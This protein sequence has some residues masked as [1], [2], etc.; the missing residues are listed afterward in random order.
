MI[1][2]LVPTFDCGPWLRESLDSVLGQSHGDREIVVVD[3]GSTDDTPAILASYGDHIRV[4]AGRHEGLAAARNLAIANARGTWIAFHDADDVA[5]PDRL[6]WQIAF[7]HAHPGWDAVFASGERLDGAGRVVPPAI[8]RRARGR[9]LNARAV[10]DGFPIFFQGALIP[11]WAF[12]A[13]GPLDPMLR[14]QP[15]IDLGYR[16]LAR[17][18]ATFVDRVVFRYRWH[19]TNT[20]RDRVA[21][22]A[23][24]ARILARVERDD[25]AATAS[26]GRRRLRA[27][28]ARHHFALARLLAAR[29]DAIGAR[30][31]ARR[32]VELRPLH[33]RYR[34]QRRRRTAEASRTPRETSPRGGV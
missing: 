21:G 28:L 22:R 32:A 3:D 7:L 1:S 29:G 5:L 26:I 6:A 25:P 2:V 34:W 8:A 9:R 14:V 30:E 33:L 19:A 18:R 4:I 16:L 20:S 31:H 13:A 23:D 10:F 12:L 15:D 17:C 27:R 24:I 11:R